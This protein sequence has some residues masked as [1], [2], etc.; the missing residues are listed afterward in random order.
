MRLKRHF[1]FAATREYSKNQPPVEKQDFI[2]GVGWS[3]GW[4][5]LSKARNDKALNNQGFVVHKMAEAMAVETG[6]FMSPEDPGPN[7]QG[8]PCRQESHCRCY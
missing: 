6:S 1:R 3:V 4:K 5:V 2:Q 8:L 7:H